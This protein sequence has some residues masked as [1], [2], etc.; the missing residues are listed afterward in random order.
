MSTPNID[1]PVVPSG[2]T[3]LSIA[4]NDAMQIIDALVQL[5]VEDKDL[6]APP[7]T[8]ESDVGKRWIVGASPSGDWSGHAGKIALCVGEDLWKIIEPKDGFTAYVL[9]EDEDY[10]YLSGSW[11]I[12]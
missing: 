6:S 1:L 12:L 7:S 4:F 11:S 9:D 8:D 3:N 5:V 10:R 2:Q